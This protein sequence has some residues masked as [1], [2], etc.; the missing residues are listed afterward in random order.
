MKR[1]LSVKAWRW[2]RTQY[3]LGTASFWIKGLERKVVRKWKKKRKKKVWLPEQSLFQEGWEGV[4]EQQE[5]KEIKTA[6]QRVLGMG[7]HSTSCWPAEHFYTSL[8]RSN[9]FA[10]GKCK[11]KIVMLWSR[12]KIYLHKQLL[13][14]LNSVI[15]SDVRNIVN[16]MLWVWVEKSMLLCNRRDGGYLS[17]MVGEG[18][19][20][21]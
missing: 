10:L 5:Q 18:I 8:G 7:L 17:L 16:L 11:N 14:F 4:T 1:L 2:R 20:N 15:L 13:Y 12:R 3:F 19:K 6:W 21:S 9:F